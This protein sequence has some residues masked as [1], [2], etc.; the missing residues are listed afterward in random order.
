MMSQIDM[1]LE[2]TLTFTQIF[3]YKASYSQ[4]NQNLSTEVVPLCIH[5]CNTPLGN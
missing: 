4:F 2:M 3:W 1:K 5:V